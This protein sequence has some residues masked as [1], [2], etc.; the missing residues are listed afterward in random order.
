MKTQQYINMEL[1]YGASKYAPLDVVIA[2]GQG[3]WVEDFEGN[4][5]MDCLSAYSAVNQGHCH[6]KIAAAMKEQIDKLTLIARL[7][8]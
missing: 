6:P 7:P 4:R 8:Q 1:Q 2:G 3:I 5:Y